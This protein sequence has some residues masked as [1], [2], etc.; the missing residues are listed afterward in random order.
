MLTKQAR[1]PTSTCVIRCKT[2]ECPTCCKTG[3]KVPHE[4]VKHVLKAKYESQIGKENDYYLC[5]NPDCNVGYYNS[6]SIFDT[7]ALK[8]P[9]W[10][11]KDANPK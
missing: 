11:K 6:K 2:M 7:S 8:K 1:A 4:T 10:Y 5:M 9:L 3:Q